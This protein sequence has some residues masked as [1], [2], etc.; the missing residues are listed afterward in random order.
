MNKLN[1]ISL[2]FENTEAVDINKK[3]IAAICLSGMTTEIH[4][5]YAFDEFYKTYQCELFH[6]QLKPQANKKIEELF[7]QEMLF[8]R[9]L[10]HNDIVSVT[11]YFS[12]F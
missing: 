5:I 7:D 10:K 9:I 12:L 1:K 11:F 8:E 2:V 6:L 4:W 3:D